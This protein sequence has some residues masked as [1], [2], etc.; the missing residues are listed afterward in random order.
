[1][2]PVKQMSLLGG[3]I[4]GTINIPLNKSFTNWAGWLVDYEAP[5]YL[6]IAEEQLNEALQALRSIGIDRTE[7]YLDVKEALSQATELESYENVNPVEIQE[8]VEKGEIAVLD[9][10]SQTEWDAGHIPGAVHIMLGTLPDR[11]EEV[12]QGQPI[13]VQCG[14]GVRSAIAAS[15]LQANGMKVVKNLLGGFERWKRDVHP[16][17]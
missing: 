10:R 5:I 6:L 15:I 12:P 11:L 14:S 3:H 9:V 1:M 13:L 17:K 16:V 7:G 8:T 2:I 4:P